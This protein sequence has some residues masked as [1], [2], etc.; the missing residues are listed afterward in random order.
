VDAAAP[1]IDPLVHARRWRTLVVLCLSLMIV[2]VGNVSVNVALP[3][4]A[5]DLDASASS[6]Q[7]VVDA[8]ALV[9]AGL[10][11][12]AGT[13]GDRFGRKGAL[14]GGLVLFLVGAAL[15]TAADSVALVIAA[16]ATMG[17]AAAFVMP[18]TLSILANVFPPDERARAISIW[19]GIA[20]G[21]GAIGPIAS[22]LVLEH[23]WWG[24]VFLVN[25]PLVVLALV[26]G[27]RLVP[28]SRDPEN[29]PLDVPGALLSIAGVGTLVYAIIEAP[30]HGWTSSRTIVPAAVAVVALALF[31]GREHTARHPMLD[32][33]LFRDRRFGVASGSMALTYFA[34]FGT[35]F[36]ISQYLQLVRGHSPL[37]SGTILL[38]IPLVMLLLAPQAPRLVARFGAA[39]VVPAGLVLVATGLVVFSQATADGSL[40]VVFLSIVPMAAGVALTGSPLTALM[41]A[42]VPL[43]RAGMGSAMNDTSREL[44]GALG[45][46]VLGS[47]VTTRFTSSLA[48]ALAGLPA[49][50]REAAGTGLPAALG[51]ARELPGGA[52]ET[53][54]AAARAAFVDGFALATLV[55]AALVVAT[56]VVASRLLP[57]TAPAISPSAAAAPGPAPAVVPAAAGQPAETP[58]IASATAQA[59]AIAAAA[60]ATAQAAATTPTT[61]ATPTQAGGGSRRPPA[62]DPDGG[63]DPLPSE[64]A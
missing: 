31:A 22:G 38:P 27:A 34:M 20:A 14:Q 2:M 62:V 9:F 18:S 8:Y 3:A 26:G 7:W 25:V 39:R 23:F 40:A 50:A 4:M 32:L 58:A 16:R 57:Q 21:G 1:E 53:L 47:L 35:F 42:A 41:M 6:L 36:L 54:A 12:M 48:P 17:V 63:L 51:V 28:T 15:A 61:A 46:A 37:A 29:Q 45:V 19:A 24:S 60:P 56:A 44:G 5:R 59:P 52:G 64:A 55:G 30:L 33:R 43:G 11:F 10:L 49:D 13:I